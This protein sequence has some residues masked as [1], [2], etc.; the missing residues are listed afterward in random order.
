[1][2]VPVVRQHCAQME[3]YNV[4]IVSVCLARRRLKEIIPC[5]KAHAGS[6]APSNAE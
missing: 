4:P 1:M 2:H 6:V 5:F 3:W